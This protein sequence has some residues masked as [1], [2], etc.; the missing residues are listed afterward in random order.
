MI[1]I[2]ATLLVTKHGIELNNPDNLPQTYEEFEE[3]VS[4]N[5]PEEYGYDS[6]GVISID[7]E[8]ERGFFTRMPNINFK[9]EIMYINIFKHLNSGQIFSHKVHEQDVYKS[10]TQFENESGVRNSI[11]IGYIVI[12]TSKEKVE[13]YNI[14]GESE[15]DRKYSEEQSYDI[16]RHSPNF[17]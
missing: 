8:K 15:A 10:Q 4:T 1:E 16:K 9:D 13:V 2:T 5:S 6:I 11:Y 3:D 17:L 12:D 7:F 14:T